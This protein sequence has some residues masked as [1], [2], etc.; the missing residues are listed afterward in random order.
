MTRRTAR[1]S[2]FSASGQELGSTLLFTR[3]VGFSGTPTDLLP[4]D[5]GRCAFAK[6]DDA[7]MLSTLTDPAVVS[8]DP[9]PRPTTEQHEGQRD[10]ELG[11]HAARRVVRR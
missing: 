11:A 7:K 6:G 2:R 1:T 8:S 4:A 10:A 5:L 3:R 9:P